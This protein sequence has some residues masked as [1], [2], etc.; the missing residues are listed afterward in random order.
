MPPEAVHGGRCAVPNEVRLRHEAGRCYPWLEYAD[1]SAGVLARIAAERGV[2]FATALFY[3]R[4]RRSPQHG[5]FIAEVESAPLDLHALPR[6]RGT[7]VIAPAA[8]Y[9]EY[10]AFGG[11][12]RLI[13]EIAAEFGLRSRVLPLAS[14][15]AVTENARRIRLAL[16]GEAHRSVILVSL[17]KGG[18][19]VRLALAGDGAARRTVRLWVQIGGL[20]CGTPLVDALLDGPWWRQLATRATLAALGMRPDTL[21]ELRHGGGGDRGGPQRVLAGPAVAP[22]GVPVINVVG[23]PLAAHLSGNTRRRHRQLAPWGPNDGSTLLRDA[24]VEPGLAYPL[25]GADHY[26]RIPAAAEL[27]Y[28]LFL[29]LARRPGAGVR[30][31]T[32]VS[33]AGA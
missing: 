8:G 32:V 3:D 22:A 2:D 4:L 20:L 25:W 16:A 24:I 7:V 6:L 1:L 27:V 33:E 21:E 26:F 28:R 9:R 18:A 31:G 10:P 5:R 12:G 19:D 29:Y 11:D 23:C 14:F 30:E 17:S 15:G 13:A